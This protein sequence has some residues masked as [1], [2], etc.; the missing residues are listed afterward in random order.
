MTQ[1]ISQPNGPL[2]GGCQCGAVRYRLEQPP[3][4]T[5][6]CHCRECQKQSASAFGISVLA[7]GATITIMQGQLKTW[8]RPTDSGRVLECHFCPD[9]GSCLFHGDLAGAAPV[10]IKG[11]SLDVMPDLAGVDHIWVARKVPGIAIPGDA[12]TYLG[13][14]DD[15]PDDETG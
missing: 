5:Y 14:P 4:K 8:Q 11:G 15:E 9:C 3:L 1:A 7:Q 13:E 12:K 2:T 10:S 6:I